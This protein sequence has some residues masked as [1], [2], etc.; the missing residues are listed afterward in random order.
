MNKTKKYVTDPTFTAEEV[1]KVS[2]AASALCTWV[3]AIYLYANV[4]KDVAP[5]R[6][7]LKE[8]LDGLKVKQDSLAAAQAELAEVTA[9]V[10]KLKDSY[11]ASVGE[12]NALQE[13][14]AMLEAKLQRAD[15][16]VT[17]LAG[18]YTSWQASIEVYKGSIRDLVGDALVAS[19]FL[20]YSGP[21]DAAYRSDLVKGWL[22]DVKSNQLPHSEGFDF[23]R[24]LANPTDVRDW[25]I[26]GLPKDDFSTENGVIV[27]RGNR[28]PLM[29]DPQAQANRWVKN[30]EGDKLRVIDLNMK[31]FL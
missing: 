13:N 19:G 1:K 25:N 12:K 26:Q 22:S 8:A 24:F 7:R 3:H 18:E 20:S 2:G 10:Q 27:T 23:A 30:L 4:A 29:I 5:K 16:L 17:G 15:K 6:A 31:D 21:F 11:D 28:W 14:A 9:K